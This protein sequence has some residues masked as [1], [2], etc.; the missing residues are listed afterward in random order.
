MKLERAW[1]KVKAAVAAKTLRASQSASVIAASW[2]IIKSVAGVSK[3]SAT[4]SVDA[5]LIAASVRAELI[6]LVLEI[7]YFLRLIDLAD[8]ASASDAKKLSF[9]KGA[10]DALGAVDTFV[11]NFGKD[12]KDS[13]SLSESQAKAV[14]K[15]LFDAAAV[16][17]KIVRSSGKSL[18]DGSA[19]IEQISKAFFKAT[20]DGAAAADKRVAAFGSNKLDTS[21]ALDS[22]AIS[23]VKPTSDAAGANDRYVY[24]IAKQLVD[25]VYVTDD[26][27]GAAS[28]E[29]DQEIAFF[30]NKTDVASAADA[31]SRTVQFS[32]SFLDTSAG[33]DKLDRSFYK[34]LSEQA[35]FVE[36]IRFA[37]ATTEADSASAADAISKS[38]GKTL[39]HTSRATDQINTK[40]FGKAPSDAPRATDQISTKGIGKTN[41]DSPVVRE[42]IAK[43]VSSPESDAFR[44]TDLASRSTIKVAT[45]GYV[46]ASYFDPDEPQYV[47]D[48][49]ALFSDV[50][51]IAFG[52]LPFDTTSAIDVLAS[53]LGKPFS[54]VSRSSDLRY[55]S[56]FKVSADGAITADLLTRFF[57]KALLDTSRAIDAISKS[58]ARPSSDSASSSDLATRSFSKAIADNAYVTDDIDGASTAQD[59]QEISFFK[60]TTDQSLVSEQLARA[61]VAKRSFTDGGSASEAKLLS[62]FKNLLESPKATDLVSRSVLKNLLESPTFASTRVNSF[63]KVYFGAE[64]LYALDYFSETYTLPY[65]AGVAELCAKSFSTK[66]SETASSTDA[67]LLNSQ[68]YC[69]DYFGESY[70]GVF[71]TF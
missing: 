30:K 46:E 60:N 65:G 17:E 14:G 5:Q 54:D 35:F 63:A 33:S 44:A 61:W 16:L 7:G 43:S 1:Q 48:N 49:I 59:D 68:N 21:R 57:S 32:R 58:V 53:S 23:V 41:V 26:I 9:Y 37:M 8:N 24:L 2:E 31:F 67:G 6:K 19:A 40:A 3:T 66:E 34:T 11:Q 15:A 55:F 45:D 69:A 71:R 22:K 70:V 13:I 25:S 52:K 12:R 20:S 42:L 28:L 39:A 4:A 38:P 50:E 51:N 47:G 10:S 64:S 29:D 36:A 27:D 62:V 18:I 56:T